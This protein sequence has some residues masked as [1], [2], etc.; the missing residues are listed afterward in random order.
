M[1]NQSSIQVETAP[2]VKEVSIHNNSESAPVDP[3]A[4]AANNEL[5]TNQE[6]TTEQPDDSRAKSKA[7]AALSKK[8]KAVRQRE[9]AI[10]AKEAKVAE[11]DKAIAYAKT[12]PIAF[13]K[14]FGIS[15][16]DYINATINQTKQLSPQEQI[17]K[18]VEQKLQQY[19]QQQAQAQQQLS[20][21][22]LNNQVQTFKSN[23]IKP[24]LNTYKDNYEIIHAT[25]QDKA[26]EYVWAVVDAELKQ[27]PR[28]FTSPEETLSFIQEQANKLESYLTD[29]L[30]KT[31]KYGSNVNRTLSDNQATSSAN[32]TL[33]NKLTGSTQPAPSNK[34][35]TPEQSK[36]AAAKWLQ[37]RLDEEIKRS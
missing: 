14:Q 17:D 37:A 20:Q 28:Q 11:Y 2:I 26:N 6:Q 8:E 30:A 36:R 27:N 13:A 35:M 24:L 15:P 22:Q 12:N 21:Q 23:V 10:K 5:Q 4:V 32:K 31:K 3:V 9:E 29:S 34:G 19:A 7:F 33:T 16:D 25:Y 1:E 18:T